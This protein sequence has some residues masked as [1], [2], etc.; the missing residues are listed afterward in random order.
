MGGCRL[1][2][3]LAVCPQEA[4]V[5]FVVLAEEIVKLKSE[6]PKGHNREPRHLGVSN[7]SALTQ[8]GVGWQLS[9]L[10]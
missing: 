5:G 3:R 6:W 2:G 9:A 7:L 10:A 4:L 1:R 8:G